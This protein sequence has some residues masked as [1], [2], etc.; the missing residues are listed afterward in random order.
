MSILRLDLAEKA[1]NGI[2]RCLLDLK[3]EVEVRHGLISVQ[4]AS[5]ADVDQ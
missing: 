5:K 4:P 3:V 2:F 1:L